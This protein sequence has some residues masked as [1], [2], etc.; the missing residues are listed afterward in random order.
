[1]KFAFKFAFEFVLDFVNRATARFILRSRCAGSKGSGRLQAGVVDVGSARLLGTP[2]SR[3]AL[4]PL[5]GALLA[6]PQLATMNSL[7]SAAVAVEFAVEFVP[8]FVAAA[9]LLGGRSWR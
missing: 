8:E 9:C 7:R 5:V 1:L 4:S 3:L 6:A 2:I